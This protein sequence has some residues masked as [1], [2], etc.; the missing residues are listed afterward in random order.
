MSEYRD[1]VAREAWVEAA[2]IGGV[3]ELEPVGPLAA[4]LRERGERVPVPWRSCPEPTQQPGDD[5]VLLG[6]GHRA[7]ELPTGRAALEQQR[8]GVRQRSGRQAAHGAVAVPMAQPVGF[9]LGLAMALADLQHELVADRVAGGRDPRALAARQIWLAELE[10]PVRGDLL[11]LS[12]QDGQPLQSLRVVILVDR[13]G[14]LRRDPDAAHA[15][16]RA[17][18]RPPTGPVGADPLEIGVV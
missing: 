5:L 14:K 2:A 15:D 9:V 4:H 10:P 8:R 1:S 17:G 11:N 12:R 3:V 16:S 7:L 18:L 6:L 13:V